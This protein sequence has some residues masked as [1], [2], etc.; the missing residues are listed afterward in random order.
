[1]TSGNDAATTASIAPQN[2]DCR[3]LQPEQDA[4]DTELYVYYRLDTSAA[5]SAL[6]VVRA[7][8]REL[9]AAHPGL[10][11][12]LLRRAEIEEGQQTWMEIYRFAAETPEV[13]LR[14]VDAAL[15]ADIERAALPLNR[16]MRGSRHL[17]RFVPCA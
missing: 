7:F 4:A 5:A 2:G 8:Q 9:C 6:A 14:G 3:A 1:M 13:P 12:R 16:F 17:E 10:Q 15:Q 11:A